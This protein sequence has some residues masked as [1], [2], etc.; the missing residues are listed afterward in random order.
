ML[1]DAWD[2][3]TVNTTK[4]CF[5]C[6]AFTIDCTDSAPGNSNEEDIEDDEQV[7]DITLSGLQAHNV[8]SKM[9]NYADVDDSV[10]VHAEV[11]H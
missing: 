8:T 5:R 11:T 9:P 4:N 7:T 6:A 3:V 10:C 2:T 1:S